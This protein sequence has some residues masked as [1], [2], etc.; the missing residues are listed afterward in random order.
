MFKRLEG[1]VVE[2]IEGAEKDSHQILIKTECGWTFRMLHYQ[3][4]CEYVRV[5]DVVGDIS[6]LIGQKIISCEEST[7][8]S[9]QALES[10][11]YTFYHL[12]THKGDV[13]LR[14]LGESNGYYSEKIDV[15]AFAPGEKLTKVW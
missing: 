9:T 2:S 10:G 6:D 4:C 3:D 5:E 14:W 8:D 12:R 7:S 15:E 13:T 11:T 1:R